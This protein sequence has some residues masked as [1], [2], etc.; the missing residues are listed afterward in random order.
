M[1]TIFIKFSQ[2][3]DTLAE[4]IRELF[5]MPPVNRSPGRRDQRRDS[6]N[7]GGVYYLFEVLAM[8]LRL[9]HNADAMLESQF[10]DYPYYL[11]LDEADQPALKAIAAHLSRHLREA[12]IDNAVEVR[13]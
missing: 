11:I 3:I 5:N 8:H 7:Y 10:G 12:G 2:D 9:V 6:M 4:T 13:L 1:V